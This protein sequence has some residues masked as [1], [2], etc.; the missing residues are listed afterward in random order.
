MLFDIG[1][2]TNQKATVTQNYSVDRNNWTFL[3]C[4]AAEI[5]YLYN[6][7]FWNLVMNQHIYISCFLLVFWRIES[8][9]NIHLGVTGFSFRWGPPFQIYKLGSGA[10]IAIDAINNDEAILHNYTITYTLED[11][12]CNEKKALDAVVTLVRDHAIDAIIGPACSSSGMGAG[13]LGSQWNIPVIAYSGTSQELSDKSVYD[14]L[15]RTTGVSYIAGQGVASLVE[16]LGWT[17]TCTYFNNQGHLI[18]IELGLADALIKRNITLTEPVFS[19]SPQ[20]MRESL[21]RMKMSC[22][23]W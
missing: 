6:Q 19:W 12:G 4:I 8:S 14:T 1:Y 21:S 3:E 20:E 7:T 15:S 17:K 13:K 18:N 9:E 16:V 22:R 23:G 5:P 2:T 10:A 11:T